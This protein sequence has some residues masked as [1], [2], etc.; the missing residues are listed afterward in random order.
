MSFLSRKNLLKIEELQSLLANYELATK[1]TVIHPFSRSLSIVDASK[2]LRQAFYMGDSAYYTLIP[3][4]EQAF[5]A[6]YIGNDDRASSAED[7]VAAGVVAVV[8]GVE[9]KTNW[10]IADAANRSN[11]FFRQ[12]C[13]LVVDDEY[14]VSADRYA[15]V[16][17][18][19]GQIIK[20]VGQLVCHDFNCTVI[21]CRGLR[22]C[23]GRCE[24]KCKHC[25]T[26]QKVCSFH[27]RIPSE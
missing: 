17:A 8:V 3:R 11:D 2:Y 12:W 22:L 6:E 26:G 18:L 7:G 5:I 16:A 15:D 24:C 19:P 13:E 27:L 21:R 1:D 10:L 14:A 9:H 23:H 4:E 20:T 25:L